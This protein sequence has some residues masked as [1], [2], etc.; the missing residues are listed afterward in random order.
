MWK[1]Y[2]VW[3]KNFFFMN[4]VKSLFLLCAFACFYW[5]GSFE[6]RI[7]N[8]RLI[9]ESYDVL[10]ADTTYLYL[11]ESYDVKYK[12]IDSEVKLRVVGNY[13][14]HREYHFI[15][16]ILWVFFVIF[17]L[18]IFFATIFDDPDYDWDLYE[19]KCETLLSFITCEIEEGKFYYLAFG[20]LLGSY[21]RKLSGEYLRNLN[22]YSLSDVKMCPKFKTKTESRVIKLRSLGI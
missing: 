10:G 13:L 17:L 20:R 19:V 21:T 18:L 11:V 15:N 2:L 22:I 8:N 6:D 12:V 3:I 9:S 7:K 1:Y 4:P 5:A 14:E 16:I